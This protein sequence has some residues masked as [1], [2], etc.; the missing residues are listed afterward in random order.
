MLLYLFL[1]F[2]HHWSFAIKVVVEKEKSQRVKKSGGRS[3]TMIIN[4]KIKE[5][6]HKHVVI[7]SI[8][9]V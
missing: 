5:L 2:L 1:S 9:V 8:I 3:F 7:I 4:T 6:I